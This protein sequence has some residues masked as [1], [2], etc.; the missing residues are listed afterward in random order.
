MEPLSR[1]GISPIESD[2][3]LNCMGRFVDGSPFKKSRSR[4]ELSAI[5]IIRLKSRS[6]AC[7]LFSYLASGLNPGINDLNQERTFRRA[8]RRSQSQRTVK[9]SVGYLAKLRR[10][11]H[12]SHRTSSSLG[13]VH[14]GIILLACRL[15]A[16]V[17]Y[18]RILLA[19]HIQL[20]TRGKKPGTSLIALRSITCNL[21]K[22]RN[23]SVR[24]VRAAWALLVRNQPAAELPTVTPGPE[25]RGRP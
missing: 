12:A 6:T 4:L 21:V 13:R 11:S 17:F 15:Y 20:G 19:A 16:A 14:S 8:R 9:Q 22:L 10:Q 5:W 25:S 3:Q 18:A 2:R 7:G 24:P 1:R 23:A